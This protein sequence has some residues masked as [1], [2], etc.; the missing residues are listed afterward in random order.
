MSMRIAISTLAAAAILAAPSAFADPYKHFP[1]GRADYRP[2]PEYDYARVVD[3][4]PIVRRVRVE[5]PQRECW[6][7]VQEVYPAS[8]PPLT[9]DNLGS[10][11]LGAV[12]GGVIGHQF[13]KG[14]G[15]DAATIAGTVIGGSVGRNTADARS[16]RYGPEER[17]VERCE[18]RYE[19][20]YEERIEGYN[21]EYEYHGRRYH[22]QLPYDPGDRIRIRVD[23]EPA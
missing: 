14:R 16:G 18:V 12:I 20:T 4:D 17:T 23:V 11:V 6:N 3:A 1:R 5:T 22:T 8:R 15:R 19:D 2:A 21:V 13:G 7:E 10:T 9:T